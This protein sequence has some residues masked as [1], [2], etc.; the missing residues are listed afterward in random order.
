VRLVVGDHAVTTDAFGRHTAWDLVPFEPV[1]IW[2]D[3]TFIEDPTLVPTRNAVRVTVPPASFRRV[4]VPV[5]PSSEITGTVLLVDGEGSSP[6]A[7]ARLELFD[8][9]TGAVRPIRAFSDGEFYEAGV[10]PGRYRL[11]L[12]P[13]YLDQTGLVAEGE[14][15]PLDVVAG[16]DGHGVDPVVLRVRHRRPR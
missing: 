16:S 6:L 11:R 10:R 13:D 12:V 3:S 8:I 14:P 7:Y 5:S 15:V 2:A 4:N 1:E 9:E